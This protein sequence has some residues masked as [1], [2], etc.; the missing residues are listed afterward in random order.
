MKYVAATEQ[1]NDCSARPIWHAC[2]Q[3]SVACLTFCSCAFVRCELPCRDAFRSLYCVS[4]PYNPSWFRPRHGARSPTEVFA[5]QDKFLLEKKLVKGQ[6]VTFELF[7]GAAMFV[8]PCLSLAPLPP[9][10]EGV[11]LFRERYWDSVTACCVF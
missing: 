7:E 8:R 11:S 10:P 3:P 4:A 2:V 5:T 9:C 1:V 6:G